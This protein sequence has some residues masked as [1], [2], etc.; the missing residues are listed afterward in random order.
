MYNW[1]KLGEALPPEGSKVIPKA[2]VSLG[3]VNAKT[4]FSSE[5]KS[6]VSSG[7]GTN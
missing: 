3:L 2:S 6:A 5:S 1:S 7:L 4:L